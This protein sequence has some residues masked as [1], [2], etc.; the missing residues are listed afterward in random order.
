M[1]NKIDKKD[2]WEF[3]KVK[4]LKKLSMDARGDV[5]EEFVKV[6]LEKLGYDVYWDNAT[7]RANK[8][9]DLRVNGKIDLEVKMATV[10]KA[11]KTFQHENLEQNRNYDAVVLLDIT[12]HTLYLTVAPKHTLP[13][14]EPNDIWTM[15]PKKMHKRDYGKDVY[16]W[17]MNI[18]DVRDREIK[19]LDDVRRMFEGVLGPSP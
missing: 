1:D 19:T 5:G 11:G 2:L 16:K 3:S 18:R 10:G 13:F 7:D 17:D 12:P 14:D 15:T 9:W 8:H 4:D 6:L